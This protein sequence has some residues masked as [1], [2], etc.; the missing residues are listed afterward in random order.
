MRSLTTLRD[1]A[2]SY[3]AVEKLR[4]LAQDVRTVLGANTKLTYAADWSEYFGHHPNDGTNDIIYHLDPL[5]SDS[6]IDA[7]GIDAYFPL[8]DWRDGDEHLDAG[9]AKNIYDL[10]YLKSN[11]EGGEGYDWY[12]ASALDRDNQI[13]TPITDGAY[14]KPFVFRY[15]DVKSWWANPHYNRFGGVEE[16]APTNWQ[17]QSKPIW[18][19]EIGCPAIDKGANQPNVFWDPKSSESFAPYY[20]T[21][22]RNDLIQRRY[23][24]AFLSYWAEANNKN[25][26]STVYNAPMVDLSHMHIWCWDARPF[27]DFPARKNIWSDGENWRTGHWISGRTGLVSLADLVN[28]VCVQQ[29]IAAPDISQLYGMVSGYIIDRPM[30]AAAALAPLSALYGFDVIEG[31]EV[32]RFVTRDGALQ[33]I[34]SL[35]NLVKQANGANQNELLVETRLAANKNPRDIRLSHIDPERDYQSANTMARDLY[36][37][38]K[39]IIDFDVPVVLDKGQAKVLSEFVLQQIQKQNS[40]LSFQLAP[41]FLHLEVGDVIRLESSNNISE[42]ELYRI[43]EIEGGFSRR[44]VAIKISEASPINVNSPEPGILSDPSW[45][46]APYGVVLDIADITGSVQRQEPAKRQGPLIGVKLEPFSSCNAIAPGGLETELLQAVKIGEVLNNIP[47]GPVARMDYANHL[48]V[49]ITNAQLASLPMADFLAGGNIF[50]VQTDLEWE[51]IQAKSIEI[52][53]QD[54][55]RLS[56]LLRAQVGS[57][58]MGNINQGANIVVLDAAIRDIALSNELKG[59]DIDIIFT[60]EGRPQTHTK[61]IHY[62]ALHQR[63]LAPVHVKTFQN[64]DALNIT[65]IRQTR[66]AG[67]DW[68]SV[69]VP[70]GE[71]NEQYEIGFYHAGTIIKS[72]SIDSPEYIA[73][74]SELEQIAG[75]SISQ[76]DIS[77]CQISQSFGHGKKTTKTIEIY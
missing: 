56:H 21:G 15:K 36:A 59:T 41:L 6:N 11:I 31:A 65:W 50:A 67:D 1:A 3:P 73:S 38:T 48:D 75:G 69:E 51:I 46:S 42:N 16:A 63:P 39:H 28:E 34:L 55:Y 43:E 24:E 53:G 45:I 20:S 37:Q 17:P 47:A 23:L 32:L 64:G 68:S 61:T 71:E 33:Q 44:L 70:L 4:V 12:Y 29:N 58:H 49:I 57:E 9:L 77:I 62:Q 7:I 72:Q 25:P 19:T 66:I 35:D 8:S 76:L 54:K 60:A 27:P 13:R 10:D 52:I 74:I 40:L 2:N 30:S 14:N 18:F 5:W 22:E 26:I